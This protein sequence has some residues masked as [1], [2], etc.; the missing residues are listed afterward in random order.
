MASR[1]IGRAGRALAVVAALSGVAA[2]A[3][4]RTGAPV[5]KNDSAA[6]RLRRFDWTPGHRDVYTVRWAGASR[7][8]VP[9]TDDL[10]QLGGTAR[11]DG[12]V[13]VRCLGR[14][15]DGT[16]TLAYSLERVRDYGLTVDGK[17]L[18]S[19]GDRR[20]AIAA[21]TG[22]EA[23]VRLDDR[24]EVASIA[25]HHDT[26]PSTRELLRQIVDMMRVTLPD[27][28]HATS[29]SAREPTPNGLAHVRY[30]DDGDALRRVRLSY[31]GVTGL[32]QGELDQ[33]LS[34]TAAIVLDEHGATRSID[35]QESLQARGSNGTFLSRWAFSAQRTTSDAFDAR[36]VKVD[37]LDEATGAS[38]LEHQRQR[39]RDERLSRGWD[40]GSIEVQLSVYGKGAHIDPKFVSSASAYVRL[41]PESCAHLVAWF[42][43]PRLTDLGRQL[44]FDV[45]SAAG[46]DEAQAAMR[47]ALGSKRASDPALRGALVQRFVFVANPTPES[48]RFVSGVYESARAAGEAPVAFRA[49]AALGAIVEHLSGADDLAAEIDK[50]LRDELAERRSPQESVALLLAL[51]NARQQD[52]LGAIEAFA[53]HEQPA[54]REQVAR[55]LRRFDDPA[56]SRDLLDMVRDPVPVVT[57]AS[58]RALR[59]QSLDDGDWD[60]LALAV[61]QGKTTTRAYSALVDLLERRPDCGADRIAR[62]LHVVLDSTPDT[63]GNR[64]LRDRASRLLAG[65]AE[66]T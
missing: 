39:D 25:Y 7:R 17:D 37:D 6:T 42:E 19:E 13:A 11:L 63:T 2:L 64:E 34:S 5:T 18:V 44:V 35:D 26:P 23:I 61:E 22:Q 50:R 45:L 27:D 14:E 31:E 30:E 55:S 66:P 33:Q 21:I 1:I 47:D 40:T 57:R 24:G 8:D 38:Q 36:A 65:A 28:G 15:T 20:L 46:S 41:H 16:A 3:F 12:D 32:G 53:G 51:G 49:A 58:F 62:M 56:A 52:D 43:D 48:A 59:E 54:V 9:G 10:K 4:G 60:S 29:W